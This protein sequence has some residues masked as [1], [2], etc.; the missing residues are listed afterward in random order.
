MSKATHFSTD[1]KKLGEVELPE[2]AFGVTPNKHVVWEAVKVFQANQRQGNAATKTRHDV[3]GGG[4]KPWRQKGTGRARQGS[5][6]SPQWKGG[7]T[8]FGPSPRDYRQGLPKKVRRLALTSAM[9][10]RAAEGNVAVVDE[11]ELKEPRTASVAGFLK[12]AGLHGR[13][14][15]VITRESNPTFVRSCRNIPRISVLHGGAINVYDMVNAD[16]LVFTT[17]AL[18]LMKEVYA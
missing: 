6:R 12:G 18:D 11:F 17:G 8:V 5:I 13:K 2:G 9:S 16:V 3:R 1:G 15:C 10:A 7:G 14:V 4:R